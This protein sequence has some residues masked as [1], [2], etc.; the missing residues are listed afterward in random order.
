MNDTIVGC[1]VLA[2][3]MGKV[4]CKVF[5]MK[6]KS[7]HTVCACSLFSIT[8]KHL[9]CAMPRTNIQWEI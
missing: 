2:K 4:V 7:L 9:Y 6:D 8:C 3:C 5:D 1:S